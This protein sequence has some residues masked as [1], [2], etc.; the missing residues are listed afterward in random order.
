MIFDSL[1]VGVKI[2][3]IAGIR[4]ALYLLLLNILKVQNIFDYVTEFTNMLNGIFTVQAVTVVIV[5]YAIDIMFRG[6]LG[7]EMWG[8]E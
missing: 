5:I 6:W 4:G 7:K 8:W 3:I 1:K 2:I